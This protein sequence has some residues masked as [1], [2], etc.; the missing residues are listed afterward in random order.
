MRKLTLAVGSALTA[1]LVT[2]L[3]L[4]APQPA[5]S[6]ALEEIT[7]TARKTTESLQEV[8]LAI[9]ALGEEDIERLNLQDLADITQQDTSVQFDEGFTPSDTRITIRGL[10]PTR[11]RPNAA[12]LVDGIDVTSEAVSNAGGSTL[13][14]PRLIDIQRIEIVKGPQ[15]ALFGR[16]A[17][18]GAIQYVT[19]DPSDTLDGEIFLNGTSK[20]EFEMRASGSIPIT[21]SLGMLVNAYGWDARGI[22]KNTATDDYLGGGNGAG[23]SVSFKWEPTDTLAMKWRTE[24][25]KDNFDV[26]AQALLNDINTIVDLDGADGMSG[27]TPG[28]SACNQTNGLPGPLDSGDCLQKYVVRQ[29]AGVNTLYGPD[30]ASNPGVRCAYPGLTGDCARTLNETYQLN[31][32]FESG[33]ANDPNPVN[34][35]DYDLNDPKF[36]DQ[37]EKTIVSFYQGQI[38]KARDLT[39]ALNPNYRESSLDGLADANDYE[40]TERTVFRT[41]LLLDWAINDDLTFISNSGFVD[42]NAKINTDLGKLWVDNCFADINAL[43]NMPDPLDPNNAGRNYLN[44]LN[45]NGY[46]TAAE[47]AKFSPQNCSKGDGIGDAATNFIQ[48]DDTDTQQISQELR[49][50]WQ[51]NESF[52][53]TTGLQYWQEKVDK[54][55]TNSTTVVGGA[56]CNLFSGLAFEPTYDPDNAGQD[57]SQNAFAAPFGGYNPIQDQCGS[58]FLAA[59]PFMADTY[60]G[61]LA[62]PSNTKR[63]T[64]HYSWY[65]SGDWNI[66]D[67]L[68]TRFEARY[69]KEDNQVTGAVQTPC[70]DGG[71]FF[72]NTSDFSDQSEC[73]NRQPLNRLETANG[74]QATGPSAVL[75]CGQTGRCDSLGVASASDSPY[76][77]GNNANAGMAGYTGPSWWAWGNLP[78]PG[79]QQTLHRTDKFWAPKLTVEYFWNNDVMTYASWSRGIKP[80]GFSLLTSGAFGLDGNLDGVYDEI[81]FEPERLD[82]W[83]LGGKTTL[84]DGRIRLNGSVFFQDFKDK[85]VTVQ[86]VTGGTTGTEVENISGSQVSGLELDMTWQVTANWL[87]RV[88]YTFLDSKYTDYTITTASSGDI[89]RINAGNP[90]QDCSEVAVIEG[91]ENDAS[92]KTGCVMSFNGNELERSPR[93]AWLVNLNY[94]NNLFDTGMEWYGEWN[95]RWQDTRWMEAFNIVEF[96][97]YGLSDL[98]FGLMGS[99]WDVQFYVNNVF[100]NDTV[101]SGGPNPGI[102]TG[103]FG[104][105]LT[106]PP[107]LGSGIN[108]GPKLPSDIYANM[109][110]PRIFGLN[111]KFRFGQ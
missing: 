34:L 58:T 42:A 29:A 14:N 90:S 33:G 106:T 94:T 2:P 38:P 43:Q 35:G 73:G 99:S 95:Y 21:D 100:D 28:S 68:S 98:R 13:I 51:I 31:Q 77:A 76:Y 12:T 26:A 25:S 11:G 50:A 8:P 16:S 86:K 92:P 7:V 61:R 55:D 80:G 6:Q 41:S 82:V 69:V 84:A 78:S 15:S 109:P 66:T 39:V 72:S 107:T 44:A 22:Y 48:D 20:D 75:I 24:Y 70:V 27:P 10:S 81:E 56:G 47:L 37:Y 30:V 74:G 105:G 91:S 54:D 87:T 45:D 79:N 32:Y 93:H 4:I 67:K 96:E 71:V 49:L 85:Q 1:L 52:N 53:F 19:K 110:N 101:I 46:N 63:Q 64:D 5:W 97:E 59:A 83:E 36:A 102:A 57:I 88:G 60:A 65:F 89:S 23:G 103:T 18:A 62:S 17:F 111:A 104:F 40:G 9:T 108:A 3:A